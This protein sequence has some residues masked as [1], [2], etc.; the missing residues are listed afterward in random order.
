[1]PVWYDCGMN[2]PSNH[3]LAKQIAVLEERMETHK[4]EYKTDIAR[5]AEQMATRENRQLLATIVIVG[6]AT[7]ILGVLITAQ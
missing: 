3:E 6:V 2:E 7:A 5:L 4:Q 1:M